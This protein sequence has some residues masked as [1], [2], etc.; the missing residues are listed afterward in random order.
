[1]KKSEESEL[2]LLSKKLQR[3][4]SLVLTELAISYALRMGVLCCSA[5]FASGL[6][7]KLTRSSTQGPSSK[8]LLQKLTSGAE[9][10]PFFVPSSISDF[11]E[12][13]RSGN[14]DTVIALG[15]ILLI[16]LPIIRVSMTVILF[17]IE[18]DWIFLLITLIVLSVL[19]SGIIFGKAL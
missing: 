2:H 14:S 8:E 1:M 13:L 6:I 10:I 4:E 3:P 17:L 7:L 16:A 12:G 19:L 5:V 11:M 9:S 18:R 15:L